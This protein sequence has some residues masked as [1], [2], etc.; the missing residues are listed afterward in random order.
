MNRV[1]G[2]LYV[3]RSKKDFLNWWQWSQHRIDEQDGVQWPGKSAFWVQEQRAL[4]LWGR[5]ERGVLVWMGEGK[6]WGKHGRILEHP[7][8]HG[9]DVRV[10]ASRVRITSK[11]FELEGPLGVWFTHFAEKEVNSLFRFSS[12]VGKAEV[13][14]EG[15]I[16]PDSQARYFSSVKNGRWK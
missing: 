16:A 1:F 15:C 11:K 13:V 7:T 5:H 10:M 14:W 12:L 2:L 6:R 4:W 8:C 3:G 9:K